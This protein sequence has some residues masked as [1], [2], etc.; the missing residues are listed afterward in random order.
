MAKRHKFYKKI[1]K[2][3]RENS[4]TDVDPSEIKRKLECAKG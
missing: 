1:E 2:R 4:L 3:K